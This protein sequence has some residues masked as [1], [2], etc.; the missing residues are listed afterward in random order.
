MIALW[1]LVALLVLFAV[2]GGVAMTKFL[3]LVLVAAL[4][5]ALIGFF[6]RAA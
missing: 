5:V 6:A 3:F 4:L 1:F 2:I